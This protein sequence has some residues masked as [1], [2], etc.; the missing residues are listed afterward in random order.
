MTFCMHRNQINGSWWVFGYFEEVVVWSWYRF[1]RSNHKDCL[2]CHLLEW[3]LLQAEHASGKKTGSGL[4]MGSRMCWWSSPQ[5]IEEAAEA[6]DPDSAHEIRNRPRITVNAQGQF[7]RSESPH[8]IL[9]GETQME[10][11]ESFR[12]I[13]GWPYFMWCEIYGIPVTHLLTKRRLQEFKLHEHSSDS[14][15]AWHRT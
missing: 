3:E 13:E 6:K 15:N 2:G 11:D 5:D 7:Q 12:D 4:T 1:S 14:P 10:S 9:W 8:A